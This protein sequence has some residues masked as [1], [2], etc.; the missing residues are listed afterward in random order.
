MEC[1]D[2]NSGDSQVAHGKA[3]LEMETVYSTFLGRRNNSGYEI[4]IKNSGVSSALL[5]R[6]VPAGRYQRVQLGSCAVNC[7]CRRALT[8]EA[9]RNDAL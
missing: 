7:G 1:W 5:M 2:G 6:F 3:K 9:K 8:Q 4:R